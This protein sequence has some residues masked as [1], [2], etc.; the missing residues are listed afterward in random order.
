M[1]EFSP[2]WL[3][4]RESI[5]RR[6]RSPA[7]LQDLANWLARKN[8]EPTIVDLGAGTGS[9]LRALTPRLGRRQ[10]WRLVEH[11]PRLIASGLA[12]LAAWTT[13]R[14]CKVNTGRNWI[15]AKSDRL[16]VEVLYEERDLDGDLTPVLDG[17]D[18]VVNS[19]LI[20][21]VSDDWLDRLVHGLGKAGL[22]AGL[23]Y[24]GRVSWS[25]RGGG[26][27]A[28]LEAFNRHQQGDKGFGR[29]LGPAAHT[30]LAAKLRQ[31]GRPVAVH[32]S[33]WRLGPG[34]PI[35][36]TELLRGFGGAVNELSAMPMRT[37]GNWWRRR[38]VPIAEGRSR[39]F[40]GHRDV[41]SLPG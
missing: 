23:A 33:P 2:E 41:L 30:T 10:K 39:V 4:L 22:Y 27:P 35:L 37:I 7:A 9:L 18:L 17:A 24:D 20:D 5:D 29:A 3:A 40:V 19:A 25:P 34:D 11:D 8:D 14:G 21:L 38:L 12:E 26:D 28:I 32:D 6:S 36:Q 13:G 31:A 16:E 15:M 1:S